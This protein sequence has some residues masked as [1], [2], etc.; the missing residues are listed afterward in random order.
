MGVIR[1]QL[2]AI[3]KKFSRLRMRAYERPAGV[4]LAIMRRMERLVHRLLP[5]WSIAIN[6]LLILGMLTDTVSQDTGVH[7][8]Y[9]ALIGYLSDGIRFR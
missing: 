5:Y 1:T 7:G 9:A 3:F 8:T 6:V 4:R 2:R